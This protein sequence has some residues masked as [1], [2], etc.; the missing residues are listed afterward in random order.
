V[1]GES[2]ENTDTRSS[3]AWAP[4]LVIAAVYV[5]A[6]FSLGSAFPFFP[7]DMFSFEVPPDQQVAGPLLVER[8]DGA[9]HR[10]EAFA[11]WQCDAPVDVVVRASCR[12]DVHV[13]FR[14]RR[15]DHRHLTMSSYTEPAG[16]REPVQLVRRLYTSYAATE[17]ERCEVATC[18]ATFTGGAG[19]FYGR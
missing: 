5:L 4:A 2:P 9:V 3:S 1:V 8:A 14:W 7:F 11:G 13:D 10:V 17:A 16:D 15:M 12:E 18:Q 19:G 6:A